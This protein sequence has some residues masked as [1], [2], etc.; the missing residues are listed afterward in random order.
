LLAEGRLRRALT[1]A[2]GLKVIDDPRRKVVEVYDLAIDPR[3][4]CNLFDRDPAR[5]DAALA[6]LRAFFAVHALRADR[7]DPPYKP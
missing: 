3:E 1:R 2:D 4:T 7:Y 5:S 6:E